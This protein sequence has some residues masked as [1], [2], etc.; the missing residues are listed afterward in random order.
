MDVYCFRILL[1]RIL[2]SGSNN[3]NGY[4]VFPK[5]AEFCIKRAVFVV[6]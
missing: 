4:V 1:V 5:K 2:S 3:V 6:Q